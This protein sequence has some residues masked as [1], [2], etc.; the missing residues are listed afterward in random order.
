MN[1]KK[2]LLFVAFFIQIQSSF[3]FDD[4]QIETFYYTTTLETIGKYVDSEHT[5]L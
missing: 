1:Y 5:T 3:A 4:N 2:Y